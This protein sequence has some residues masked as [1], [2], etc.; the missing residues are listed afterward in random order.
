MAKIKKVYFALSDLN[1][2]I[3]GVAD[4]LAELKTTKKD[5]QQNKRRCPPEAARIKAEDIYKELWPALDSDF[6][7]ALKDLPP[8]VRAAL[9]EKVGSLNELVAGLF[10][11]L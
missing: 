5:L 4:S 7:D 1:V 9:R 10:Q 6:E 11:K 2:P 8:Q 3:F